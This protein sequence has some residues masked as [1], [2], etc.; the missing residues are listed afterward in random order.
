MKNQGNMAPVKDHDH[1]P[2]THPKDMEAYTLPEEEFQIPV[3]RKV[4]DLQENTERQFNKVRQTLQKQNEKI[5][6]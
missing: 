6:R 1:F 2:G 4:R 5:D 3:L